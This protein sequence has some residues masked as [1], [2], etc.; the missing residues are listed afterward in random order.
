MRIELRS[1]ESSNRPQEAVQRF[2]GALPSAIDSHTLLQ[3]SREIR[4]HHAGQEYRLRLTQ[5]DK[6][7][8][9]K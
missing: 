3:G 1:S 6:L 9:T 2:S 7:I 5:N 8:L 4:I